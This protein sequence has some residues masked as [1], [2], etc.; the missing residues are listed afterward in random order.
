L[1]DDENAEHR[2]S[3][4]RTSGQEGH[5]AVL[6]ADRDGDWFFARRP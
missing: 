3:D 1:R 5:P 2:E 6:L 4:S